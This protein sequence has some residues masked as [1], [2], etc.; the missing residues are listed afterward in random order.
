MKDSSTNGKV[1]GLLEKA[2]A[3]DPSYS[4]A[5][6]LFVEYLDQDQRYQEACNLLQK[7]VEKYPSSKMHQLLAENLSR[8]Q[9]DEEAFTHYNAALRLD[10]HNQRAIE[11]MN[12]LAQSPNKLDSSLSFYLPELPVTPENNSYVLQG[13]S[14]PI[15]DLE[16]SDS[17]QWQDRVE[18]DSG[19][20]SFT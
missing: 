16:L 14:M 4:P 9:K 19:E 5:V 8:L 12:R 13:P 20:L 6:C 17:D 7:H 1:R 10:P 15:D 11:G 2:I 18:G 3:D